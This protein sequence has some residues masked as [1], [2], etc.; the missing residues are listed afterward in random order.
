M[1]K[2]IKF[3]TNYRIIYLHDH[4]T[5]TT[6]SKSIENGGLLKSLIHKHNIRNPNNF[7]KHK[8]YTIYQ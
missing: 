2:N 1:K 3:K 8:T 6:T 5:Q 4:I 7:I